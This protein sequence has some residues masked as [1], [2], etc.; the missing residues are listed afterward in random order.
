MKRGNNDELMK[1]AVIAFEFGIPSPTQLLEKNSD[2]PL[3]MRVD[4]RK[5]TEEGF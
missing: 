5:I 1:F 3:E 4:F 2:N